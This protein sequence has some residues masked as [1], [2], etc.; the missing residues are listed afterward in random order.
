MRTRDVVLSMSLFFL[1]SGQNRG[2]VSGA[3][4][5]FRALYT[6]RS[7][8]FS[9]QVQF[10][11]YQC[12]SPAC[13]VDRRGFAILIGL[14][15]LLLDGSLDAVVVQYGQAFEARVGTYTQPQF[16]VGVGFYGHGIFS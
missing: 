8:K 6:P 5:N 16:T 12:K 1:I 13:A 11:H 14:C 9:S 7:E 4:R 3:E 2:R 15:S 10:I